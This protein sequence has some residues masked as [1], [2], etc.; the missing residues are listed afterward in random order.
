[1]GGAVRSRRD[2][3]VEGVGQALDQQVGLLDRGVVEGDAD[4]ETI[5]VAECRDVHRT[6]KARAERID[7]VNERSA[8]VAGAAQPGKGGGGE[9]D[10]VGLGVEGWQEEAGGQASERGGDGGGDLQRRLPP[11]LRQPLDDDTELRTRTAHGGR[12]LEAGRGE[13][14]AAH[15]VSAALA[16]RRGEAQLGSRV[17]ELTVVAPDAGGGGGHEE[18]VPTATEGERGARALRRPR[19]ARND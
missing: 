16:G 14:V 8:D 2:V 12:N 15:L 5:V 3:A 4:V 17:S 6:A 18:I 19:S 11:R 1:M 7:R 10:G 9:V 13:P